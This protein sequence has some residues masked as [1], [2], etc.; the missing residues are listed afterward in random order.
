MG[1]HTLSLFAALMVLGL[2][3]ATIMVFV[4]FEEPPALLFGLSAI[5]ILAPPI[6]LLAHLCLT[7][8]LSRAEKQFWL[9]GL[10]SRKALHV[11]SAYLT[12]LQA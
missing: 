7:K 6:A 5:C 4:G 8:G 9:R 11:A 2:L 1:K 3:G 10:F 12:R